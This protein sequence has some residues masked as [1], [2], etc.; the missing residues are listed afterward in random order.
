MMMVGILGGGQ[1]ARMLALAGHPLG[2]RCLVLDPA[3]DAC[4]A[5]VAKHL[6]G[7]FTAPGLLEH[8]AER[9]DVVTYEFENVPA[10]S[11]HYLNSRVAVYPPPAALD[12]ARDRLREKQLF[13]QLNIATPAFTAVHTVD[14][15]TQ[16]VQTMTLPAVLKTRTLG[17]D[18]K[19]QAV[20]RQPDEAASAWSRLGGVPAI[21]ESFV[22]FE[23]ELS[24]VAARSRN[25]KTVYYPVTEN[26][27][28]DGILHLSISRPHDA[29]QT[30]AE[31]YI[32]RIMDAL[33]YVGVLTLELFQSGDQLIANEIAPRVH[34]SGHWTIEGA[35]TSQFENHLRAIF[36]WP[37]GDT[38]PRGYSAMVNFVGSIP[39]AAEVLA[40]S[41][42]HHH[43]YGKRP[44]PGRKLGHATLCLDSEQALQKAIAPLEKLAKRL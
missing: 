22:P 5:A 32:R 19:G 29:M 15:L 36:D 16:A 2:L 4:A 30:R 43:D 28:R 23:R 17:Y 1:L 3:P 44:Q 25:G 9:A 14:E 37:L 27:H 12:V 26:T 31:E 11:V 10:P 6:A 41:C 24:I 21:L 35:H 18:G 38:S 8:F 39:Q 40:V 20:I 42:A 33:N 34:N 13:Q 7:D